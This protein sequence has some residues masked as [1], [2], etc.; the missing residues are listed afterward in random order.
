[1]QQCGAIAAR[2]TVLGGPPSC[3]V[4]HSSARCAV[5][6]AL[7]R[8]KHTQITFSRSHKVDHGTILQTVNVFARR[9]TEEKPS[10]KIEKTTA[11]TEKKI[12]KRKRIKVARRKRLRNAK[13]V[14]KFFREGGKNHPDIVLQKPRSPSVCMRG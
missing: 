2:H 5:A 14:P 11:K 7:T 9:V 6:S 1:M 3:C 13:T 12:E 10:K 8:E 4:Q